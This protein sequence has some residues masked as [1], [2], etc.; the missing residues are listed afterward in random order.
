MIGFTVFFAVIL[1]V[2]FYD[3]LIIDLFSLETKTFLQEVKNYPY[4]TFRELYPRY[5]FFVFLAI[6]LSKYFIYV[7]VVLLSLSLFF[8]Y[9]KRINKEKLFKVYLLT[10]SLFLIE[11]SISFLNVNRLLNLEYR[12]KLI[13]QDL[14]IRPKYRADEL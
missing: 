7:A 13:T 8:L 6:Q 10:A 9:K 2:N 11:I 5:Y 3:L 1:V 4:N 12:G 14:E